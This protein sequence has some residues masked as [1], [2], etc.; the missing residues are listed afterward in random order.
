L[1]ELWNEP[2]LRR[3]WDAPLEDYAT[4]P[5]REG[6]AAL[7]ALDPALR[8]VLGGLAQGHGIA[9]ILATDRESFDIASLHYYP[10]RRLAGLR[11]R[12]EWEVAAFRRAL[13][14]AG[15][16]ETPVWLTEVGGLAAASRPAAPRPGVR[17]HSDSVRRSI[18]GSANAGTIGYCMVPRA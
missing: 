16:E 1:W 13:R 7:R 18:A 17:S 3:Y 9:R 8:V 15:L 11:A 6:A 10:P 2:N 12:P 4:G 5:L 14:E